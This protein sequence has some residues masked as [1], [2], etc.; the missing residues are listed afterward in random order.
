MLNRTK[1][2]KYKMEKIRIVHV[3]L[4][5]A[6]QQVELKNSFADLVKHASDINFYLC[7]LSYLTFVF[8]KQQFCGIV[9]FSSDSLFLAHSIVPH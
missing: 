4:P 3:F 6:K 1:P 2:Q 5:Q 8:L 7:L 9:H